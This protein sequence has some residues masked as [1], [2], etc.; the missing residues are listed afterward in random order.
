MQIHPIKLFSFLENVQFHINTPHLIEIGGS[1]N[2]ADDFVFPFKHNFK[3][4]RI[5]GIKYNS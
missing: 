3:V 5:S 4:I 2:K 1:L